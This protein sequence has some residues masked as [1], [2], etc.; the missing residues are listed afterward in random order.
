MDF[1]VAFVSNLFLRG[2]GAG[3][4][5]KEMATLPAKK[6]VYILNGYTTKGCWYWHR[7]LFLFSFFFWSNH[8]F[9]PEPV[10][11]SFWDI[12][13]TEEKEKKMSMITEILGASLNFVLRQVTSLYH[14]SPT[15]RPLKKFGCKTNCVCYYCYSMKSRFSKWYHETWLHPEVI[16]SMAAET[17]AGISMLLCVDSSAET[18]G[19]VRKCF[20][21]H[22]ITQS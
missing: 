13:R 3:D 12:L 2:A 7:F 4:E 18:E 17:Y 22:P 19:T 9:Y 16:I 8:N 10:N 20:H 11:A 6:Q 21:S 5:L 14:P 1:S 15:L